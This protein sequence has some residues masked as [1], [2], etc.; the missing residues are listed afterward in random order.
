MLRT[1][2]LTDY[3]VLE[4]MKTFDDQQFYQI[5]GIMQQKS[6][7][8]NM[9]LASFIAAYGRIQLNKIQRDCERFGFQP[10]YSDTD[11]VYFMA[12]ESRLKNHKEINDAMEVLAK[13]HCHDTNL[14]AC[15]FETVDD[16]GNCLQEYNALHPDEEPLRYPFADDMVT[17]AL[18]SYA[19]RNTFTGRYLLK[20]KGIPEWMMSNKTEL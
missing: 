13:V 4:G 3:K 2:V 5:G 7:R 8:A 15:K 10:V 17:L 9:M 11:S 1:G 14:G 16:V 19:L 18:K 12:D 20:G 6:G